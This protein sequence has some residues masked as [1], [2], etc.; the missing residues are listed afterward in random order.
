MRKKLGREVTKTKYIGKLDELQIINDAL[1][2]ITEECNSEI[3]IHNDN[4]YDPK[5][6]AKN[7]IPYKPAIYME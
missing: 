7:A 6:K 3:I 1:D 2:Y 5:N 4:S